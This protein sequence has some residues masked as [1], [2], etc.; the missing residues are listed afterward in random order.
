VEPVRDSQG[1][2]VR[3]FGTNT[4]ITDQRRIEEELRK[5]NRELEE[6]AYVASHDLQE[7]LRMVNIYTHLILRHIGGDDPALNQYGSFV[8]QG[9]MRMEG[10]IRDLLTF[11]RAVHGEVLLVGSADLTASLA[12]ATSVLKNSIESAQ[13]VINAGPLPTVRGD[14][15]QLSHVFQNLISNALKYHKKDV[16]PEISISAELEGDEWIIAVRDNGIG[17]EPRYASRIFGL[18]KRLHKDE[19]PGTGLGL[20]ICQRVVERCGGRM[21]AEGRPGEG[22]T[23]FFA[24]MR[25]KER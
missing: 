13:A 1:R 24:L 21:W 3:W 14:T 25:T 15:I 16:P 4:D 6:F 5:M 9:V 8:H 12:D 18:F 2:V 17:F 20:A 7:P 19:Y 22:A 10:L 23:F 11:S